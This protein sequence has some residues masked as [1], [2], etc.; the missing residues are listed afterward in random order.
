MLGQVSA[1]FEQLHRPF[2][3]VA[4]LRRAGFA[5]TLALLTPAKFAVGL[6]TILRRLLARRAEGPSRRG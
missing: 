1:A 6:F 5:L 4:W 3:Q 2:L